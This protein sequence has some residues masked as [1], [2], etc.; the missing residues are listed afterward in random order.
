MENKLRHTQVG[1]WRLQASVR[2]R[3]LQGKA[4]L[5]LVFILV[6]KSVAVNSKKCSVLPRKCKNVLP[7]HCCRATKNFVLPLTISFNINRLTPNDPYMGLP[8]R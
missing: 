4:T 1:R 7:L 5:R 8:H 6:A 2:L 3:T